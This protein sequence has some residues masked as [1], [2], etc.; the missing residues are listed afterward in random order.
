MV[1]DEAKEY[2]YEKGRMDFLDK[3]YDQ[4]FPFPTFLDLD[5]FE[6]ICNNAYN[7]GYQEE[8]ATLQ[9]FAF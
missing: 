8:L 7:Q 6:V 3:I 1:I 2:Y 9:A 5:D 4:P